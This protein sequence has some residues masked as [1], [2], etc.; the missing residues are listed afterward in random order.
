MSKDALFEALFRQGDTALVLGHRLS[1]W[2]GHAPILEEDIAL[3][4][5]ALDL[6]GQATSLLAYAGEVEG[7][8]RNEDALAY[9]RDGT[10]YRNLL[11]VEQ[12]NEDFGATMARQF[13]HDARDVELQPALAR[14]TDRR[15]A[16]IA[17]K[18]AKEAS[19]HYRHSAEWL[20]RL[21]DGTAESHAR[22]QDALD[23]LWMFTGEM[24]EADEGT[25]ALQA[26]GV[27]PDMAAIR[28]AWSHR[29]DALLAEATLRRPK[30][31]WMQT[32]GL[33]GRHG[34]A[35]GHMLAEMQHLQR[36]HP[37]ATW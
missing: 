36:A 24:F 2:C 29:V 12:P 15:L 5:I 6:T 25:L 11:L 4:N 34:E 8:G 26:A 27:L 35:L 30:D 17:A 22:V 14:S 9:L 13:L 16:G 28:A 1:E 7:E 33:T 20:I 23:T 37:G 32:G 10:L 18:A 21:G 3:T 19:Y 31:G